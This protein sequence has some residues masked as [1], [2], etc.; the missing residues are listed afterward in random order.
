MHSE[1]SMSDKYSQYYD[2]IQKAVDDSESLF[3]K[4]IVY[5]SGGALG[6]SF[7]FIDKIVKMD[8]A[9]DK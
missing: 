9:K 1:Y 4:N 2:I 6:V 5:L 7:T 8:L 3:E